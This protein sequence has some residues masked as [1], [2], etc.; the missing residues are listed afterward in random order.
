WNAG[1]T[2]FG[3]GSQNHA[4]LRAAAKPSECPDQ[5]SDCSR[6]ILPGPGFQRRTPPVGEIAPLPS[7]ETLQDLLPPCAV[8]FLLPP[9]CGSPWAHSQGRTDASHR[10]SVLPP[11]V[12]CR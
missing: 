7:Q 9:T 1:R 11:A 8:L 2:L 5:G 4:L 10:H 3:R 12:T 6:H